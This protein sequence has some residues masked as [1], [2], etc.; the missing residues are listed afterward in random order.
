MLKNIPRAF[1]ILMVFSVMSTAAFAQAG[2][3]VGPGPDVTTV[4][5]V[6]QMKDDAKVTLHGY[7]MKQHAHELYLFQDGTGTVLVEIDA[8]K[9]GGQT[10]T[11]G[12]K[13]QI[14]GEIDIDKSRFKIDV[15]SIS[16]L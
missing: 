12:D 6:K 14:Q 7:I 2:G 15:E 10:V 4:E 9:W 13:V 8:D 1:L 3:F 16:K 11:P 5:E